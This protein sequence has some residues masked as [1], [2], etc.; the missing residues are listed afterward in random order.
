MPDRREALLEAAIAVVREGGYPALTQPRVAAIA[1][2]SQGHLTYYFPTR[3]DLLGA[4]A[5]RI[6]SAQLGAFDR[7]SAPASADASVG[8]ITALVGATETTRVFTAL[9]QAADAEPVAREALAELVSGMRERATRLLAELAGDAEH[10]EQIAWHAADGRLLHAA[11]V[12]A[13]VLTLAEGDRADDEA[14][15]SMLSR[16]VERL[17][18]RERQ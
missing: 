17:V 6:V 2:M 18:P 14:T 10:P 8:R 16:L 3:A 7:R 11:A 15:A 1:G 4:V 9:L 5:E 12:G 13:A